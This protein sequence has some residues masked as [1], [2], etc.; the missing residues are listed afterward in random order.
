MGRS[1][2]PSVC[3][4]TRNHRG[5]LGRQACPVSRNTD[6]N[7]R[8]VYLRSLNTRVATLFLAFCQ[9]YLDCCF[10]LFVGYRDH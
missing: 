4:E 9:V 10:E 2:S 5:K 7:L 6:I 3:R 8:L 1:K